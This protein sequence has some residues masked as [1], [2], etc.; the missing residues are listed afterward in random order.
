MN[1][2]LNLLALTIYTVFGLVA[3]AVVYF[4]LG[5]WGRELDRQTALPADDSNGMSKVPARHLDLREDEPARSETISPEGATEAKLLSKLLAER[6]D[7]VADLRRK[8]QAADKRVEDMRQRYDRVLVMMQ[9]WLQFAE[10]VPM[11]GP[12][13]GASRPAATDS[14]SEPAA[15]SDMERRAL[16]LREEL[17]EITLELREREEQ[18]ADATVQVIEHDAMLNVVV[19]RLLKPSID[20]VIPRLSNLLLDRRVEVRRWACQLIASIGPAARDS[21]DALKTLLQSETD[22]EVKAAANRALEAIAD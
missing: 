12:E 17:A 1:W 5:N 8:L 18:L 7:Q 14:S 21:E 15:A 22:E 11:G 19:Q 4:G 9:D 13:T 3:G 2:R 10:A 6:T 16:D 20:Q